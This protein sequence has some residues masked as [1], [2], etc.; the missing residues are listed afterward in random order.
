VRHPP[1][2]GRRLPARHHP[3]RRPDAQPDT[4]IQSAPDQGGRVVPSPGIHSVR[5]EPFPR[6]LP[7]YRSSPRR[8]PP[9]RR[10]AGV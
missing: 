9:H 10:A 2:A 4:F 8:P 5:G 6:A 7:A 3:V 1:P